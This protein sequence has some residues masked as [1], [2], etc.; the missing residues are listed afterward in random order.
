LHDTFGKADP[1]IAKGVDP[2]MSY[3]GQSAGGSQYNQQMLQAYGQNALNTD[4]YYG[5]ALAGIQQ[6]RAHNF[7][8]QNYGAAAAGQ[9]AA[10]AGQAMEQ[11]AAGGVGNWLG[12]G[13][14]PSVAQAQLAQQNNTNVANAM[15]LA[16][17]GRGQ[18]GGAAA[19]QA[20]AFQAANMGQQT[21]QQAATL[22]AQEAQNWR[23]QQLQGMGMQSS[24]G[25]NLAQQGQAQQQL[26]L[27]YGQLGEQANQSGNATRLSA[28]GMGQQAQQGYMTQQQ[29]QLQ[30][31]QQGMTQQYLGYLGADTQAQLA[32]QQSTYQHQ[33]GV[34]GLLSAGAGALAMLSDENAKENIEPD[35]NP[36]DY[37]KPY[38][39]SYKDKP[40]QSIAKQAAK[41]AYQAALADAKA[42]RDGVMAQ[43]LAKSAEGRE[44]LVKTPD[45]LGINFSRAMS[46]LFSNQAKLNHRLRN[47]EGAV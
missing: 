29:Q 47:I 22:R 14:G 3:Y 1:V 21:N 24:I 35:E 5:N 39:Y 9:Q 28:L 44:T 37:L 27:G 38:K 31:E 41:D 19:Q 11:G 16:S 33:G 8:L 17:S 30:N 46:F 4:L 34:T 2:S 10:G 36:L 13:P 42:P 26:G 32:N 18:G 15:A 6:G 20:A 43:D 25:A 45:G 40:A 7:D 12:Q 23:Q